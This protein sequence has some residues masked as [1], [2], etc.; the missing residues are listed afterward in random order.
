MKTLKSCH[1]LPKTFEGLCRV[2][3]PRTIHD[4]VDLKNTRELVDVLAVRSHLNK[5]QQDYLDTLSTLVEEYENRCSPIAEVSGLDA[6]KFLL[7]Q[8]RL[9]AADLSRILGKDPSLGS[10]ILNRERRITVNHALTLANHFKVSP[11][12]FIS[13]RSGKG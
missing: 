9:R 3:M 2:L 13:G 1:D 5:D 6:L 8:H 12:T 11:G 10:K 7:D 4:E